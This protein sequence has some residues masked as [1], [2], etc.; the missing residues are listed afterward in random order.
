MKSNSQ[1]KAS[2]KYDKKTYRQILLKIRKDNEE[3]LRW[4]DSKESKNAYILELIQ[5][6]IK[7]KE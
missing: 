4:L 2:N 6:D 3:V 1:I 7:N 5:K